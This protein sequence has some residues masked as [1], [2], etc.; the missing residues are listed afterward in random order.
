MR[1]SSP[2]S[3]LSAC[4]TLDEISANQSHGAAGCD[5]KSEKLL[6]GVKKSGWRHADNNL[7]C[8]GGRQPDIGAAH[9]S[10]MESHPALRL[11]A[12]GRHKTCGNG[13]QAEHCQDVERPK[14]AEQPIDHERS[15]VECHHRQDINVSKYAVEPSA[16]DV[17][18][19]DNAGGK[20][21][22]P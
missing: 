18:E 5:D 8:G 21:G 9:P 1:P 19:Y 3:E 4:I 12:I 2:R 10:E 17:E 11:L 16:F 20:G 22:Q 7:G 6:L 15:R 14:V 13:Q